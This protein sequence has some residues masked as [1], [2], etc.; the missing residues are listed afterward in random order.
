M[1]EILARARF[2]QTKDVIMNSQSPRV[3]R[4]RPLCLKGRQSRYNITELT[5]KLVD[6]LVS[7]FNGYQLGVRNR[8]CV[9]CQAQGVN[10]RSSCTFTA[11]SLSY[12]LVT[13]RT[14]TTRLKMLMN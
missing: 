4:V 8:R 1:Y 12:G 14:C 13:M 11:Y 10:C 2:T 7:L 3:P 6:L 9:R 5:A